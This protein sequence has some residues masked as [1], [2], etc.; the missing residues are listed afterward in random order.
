MKAPIQNLIQVTLINTADTG[1][2][3][4]V[5][6]TRLLKA[7][8]G[9][10]NVQMLVQYKK[11]NAPEIISILKTKF[12][13]LGARLN[14]LYER[15]PFIAFYE[16]NKQVRFAFSTANV[17]TNISK[18]NI[19]KEADVLHIHWINSGFLS[20]KNLNQL[21]NLRKPIVFTLHDMWAF[22]GG[23][24]YAGECKNFI[25]N[26]GA[27]KFLRNPSIN[28]ISKKGWLSKNNL[29][30]QNNRIVF[31]ACSNWMAQMAKQS[32]LLAG[33]RIEIIPNPIDTLIYKPLN[34]IKI[35]EKWGFKVDATLI[36][37]GAANIND[38]RKGIAYLIDALQI[39]KDKFPS[40][41]LQIVLF[42]K[43]NLLDVSQFPFPTKNLSIITAEQDLV[44]IYNLADVF[45][46]PSLEDNLPNMVMEAM[47]CGVPVVAFNQGGIPEMIDHKQN[48]YVAQYQS[49]NDFAQ[50]INWVLS[51]DADLLKNKARQKVLDNY[52]ETMVAQKYIQ[53]YQSLQN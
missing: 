24:H 46:L 10:V 2:G 31:V 36:I 27:C 41:K 22:T 1:G 50:G 38:K 14:F 21:F 11:N 42:G 44:E 12:E 37:F 32:S 34:K 47:A 5:A 28:D 17:G 3:A 19:I 20:I 13:F 51:K 49:A 40:H 30:Q 33:A 29:Y 35:R 25:E 23:C 48:G 6:C 15:L 8:A 39:L 16:K 45:V 53:V 7:L 9:K 4:A 18:N 26:C 43:N 52:S